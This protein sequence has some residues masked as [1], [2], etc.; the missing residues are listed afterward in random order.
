VCCPFFFKPFLARLISAVLVFHPR[1]SGVISSSALQKEI[2]HFKTVLVGDISH[3][4][5]IGDRNK[6]GHDLALFIMDVHQQLAERGLFS[7]RLLKKFLRLELDK[8]HAEEDKFIKGI[9]NSQDNS[10]ASNWAMIDE[11]WF[12]RWHYFATSRGGAPPPGLI[13]NGTLLVEHYVSICPSSIWIICIVEIKSHHNLGQAYSAT[14]PHTFERLP[15]DYKWLFCIPTKNT[16]WWAQ[17][18]SNRSIDIFPAARQ[19]HWCSSPCA[20]LFSSS[21][22]LHEDNDERSETK[23][24][25]SSGTSSNVIRA[26]TPIKHQ[27]CGLFSRSCNFYSTGLERKKKLYASWC[28][29]AGLSNQ[30]RILT[31]MTTLLNH[32]I[33]LL[34]LPSQACTLFSSIRMIGPCFICDRSRFLQFY[35]T[36]TAVSQDI[37][38]IFFYFLWPP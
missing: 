26:W 17:H 31:T 36:L 6:R 38:N 8:I 16:W 24:I 33:F 15:C 25:N 34:K 14:L 9:L 23:F 22:T 32:I 29:S 18:T 1:S 28:D 11:S 37:L 20:A 35:R 30:T 13:S 10:E 2:P 19:L 21:S 7:P 5:L 3:R 12:T 4:L 27:R